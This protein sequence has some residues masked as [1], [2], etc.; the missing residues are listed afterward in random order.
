MHK[1]IALKNQKGVAAL[2]MLLC[3]ML[4][5]VLLSIALESIQSTG[6]TSY[7]K[8]KRLEAYAKAK[9][10]STLVDSH[11]TNPQVSASLG[12]DCAIFEGAVG[13]DYNGSFV[14]SEIFSGATIVTKKQGTE[15]KV[16]GTH[17][18]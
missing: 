14:Y 13:S 7:E 12:I 2:E 1:N 10:C 11:Y 8:H 3:I 17:Y 16:H 5:I 18:K 9:S 4:V 15:V 6:K